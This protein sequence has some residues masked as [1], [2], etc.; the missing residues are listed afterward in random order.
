MTASASRHAIRSRWAALLASIV[1]AV[2]SSALA[3]I[4]PAARAAEPPYVTYIGDSTMAGLRPT[5]RARITSALPGRIE[6]FSCRRLI[7]KSCGRKFQTPNTLQVMKA[8]DGKMGDAIVIMAGY[9]DS[10]IGPAIDTIIEEAKRQSI[11][12]VIWL[13]YRTNVP[14]KGPNAVSNDVTF[15]RNNEQLRQATSRHPELVLADWDTI[16]QQN[17]AWFTRDGIH[18]TAAGSGGLATFLID[19]LRSVDVGRCRAARSNPAVTLPK[20]DMRNSVTQS[21][22]IDGAEATQPI[23]LSDTRS[24]QPSI[25]GREQFIELPASPNPN[26]TGAAIISITVARGCAQPAT[27]RVIPCGTPSAPQVEVTVEPW[28]I[29]SI[30]TVVQPNRCLVTSAT[31]DVIVDLIGW[32]VPAPPRRRSDG[33]TTT[34]G[35]GTHRLPPHDGIVS[36]ASATAGRGAVSVHRCGDTPST[37]VF[38]QSGAPVPSTWNYGVMDR[39]ADWCVTVFGP[40][41]ITVT[42]QTGSPA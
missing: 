14:Y 13:T 20:A 28:G 5:D 22:I 37:S 39:T 23:R 19:T 6:A 24:G 7:V 18:I 38:T 33:F 25:P 27:L 4:A 15:R 21:D 9:D 32:F 8:L 11:N 12:S 1:I 17:P 29:G 40:L 31:A 10:D 34:F 41:S 30:Q 42:G 16:G 2:T 26:T 3:S 35:A 36:V